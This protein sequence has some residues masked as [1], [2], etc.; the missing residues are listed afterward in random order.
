MKGAMVMTWTGTRPGRERLALICGRDLD[1]FFGK[2]V[3][4]GKCT[5]PTWFVPMTGPSHWVV[6]GEIEDLLMISASPE[7]QNLIAKGSLLNEGFTLQFCSTD[8]DTVFA[9]EE[10]ILD[11]LK[12]G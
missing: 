5:S 11:E 3:A 4:E 9:T 6:E 2:F 1:D 10:G 8:R 7:A 12:I